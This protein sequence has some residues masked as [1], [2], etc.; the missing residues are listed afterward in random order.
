MANLRDSPSFKVHND[1]Y[2]PKSAWAMIDHLIPKD[3]IVWEACMLNSTLSK[4]PQYL[5][6]LGNQV[7]YNT[8]WDVLSENHGDII[9]SNPP[10]ETKLKQQI[11]TR[12]VELDKPFIIIMNS[13]NVYTKY[14]TSILDPRHIQIINPSCK[15]NFDKMEQ[16][17]LKQ[18]KGCSFYRVFVAYK[19]KLNNEDCFVSPNGSPQAATAVPVKAVPQPPLQSQKPAKKDPVFCSGK[20]KGGGET[21]GYKVKGGARF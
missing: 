12:L 16:G 20:L 1:Y 17:E 5:E 13:L 8:S 2:T 6:E 7:V 10:F 19:M 11:L 15:I 4:S 3:K 14:F 18:T 21:C 9:V